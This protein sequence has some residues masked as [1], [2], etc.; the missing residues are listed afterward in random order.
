MCASSYLPDMV[1]EAQEVC[2]IFRRNTFRCN[3][4]PSDGK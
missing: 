1:C 3:H 2:Q 4:K